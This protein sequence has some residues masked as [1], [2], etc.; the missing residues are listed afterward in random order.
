MV[1]V[2]IARVYDETL[3]SGTRV[4]I[5]R[6]W[7]RGMKKADAPIDE[8]C[9]DVAPSTEL[10]TWFGH[11]PERFDEFRRRYR[12]ELRHPPA[13]TALDGLRTRPSLVLMTA[14]KDVQHSAAAVLAE[15][16]SS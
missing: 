14:T 6:L 12:D 5:D 15:V 2:I 9:K 7:P 8:W 13:S 11:D 1:D 4:L 10:R 16:L 3:P